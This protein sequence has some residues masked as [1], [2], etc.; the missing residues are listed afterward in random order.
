LEQFDLQSGVAPGCYRLETTKNSKDYLGL[1]L[2]AKTLQL[3][4]VEADF[5]RNNLVAN[6]NNYKP[7]QGQELAWSK[8]IVVETEKGERSQVEIDFQQ[9][10]LNEE[11]RFPFE[12]PE[13]YK[14]IN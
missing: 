5:A 8:K 6:F 1:W 12:V 3:L 2:H 7:I 9:I 11:L 14:Q 4:K 13:H 10:S